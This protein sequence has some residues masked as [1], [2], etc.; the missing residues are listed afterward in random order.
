MSA[1]REGFSDVEDIDPSDLGTRI[2]GHY[3]VAA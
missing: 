2:Q 3:G 1:S